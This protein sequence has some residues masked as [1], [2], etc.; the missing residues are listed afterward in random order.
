MVAGISIVLAAY[1]ALALLTK[2]PPTITRLSHTKVGVLVWLWLASL[3]IH[4]IRGEYA[5]PIEREFV[6]VG[7]RVLPLRRRTT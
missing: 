1:E 7:S 6:R 2:R 3:A 5:P 4:L